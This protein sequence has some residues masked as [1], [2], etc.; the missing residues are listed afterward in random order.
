MLPA[1]SRDRYPRQIRCGRLLLHVTGA[2]ANAPAAIDRE[3]WDHRRRRALTLT[4]REAWGQR[5]R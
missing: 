4:D 3:A 2:G 1:A 5:K